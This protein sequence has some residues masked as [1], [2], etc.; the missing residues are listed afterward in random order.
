MAKSLS[1]R[2]EPAVIVSTA[3]AAVTA[4]IALLVAFGLN[5]TQE[6]TAAILGVVAVGAPVVAG[7]LTRGKVYAPASVEGAVQATIGDVSD[8]PDHRA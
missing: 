8:G 3:T 5:L 7:A 6:Q 1:I 2:T 4:V